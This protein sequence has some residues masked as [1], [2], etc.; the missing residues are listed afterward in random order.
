MGGRAIA[1]SDRIRQEWVFDIRDDFFKMLSSCGLYRY[2]IVG[3]AG[4]KRPEETSG[5]IDIVVSKEELFN[6][7]MGNVKLLGAR[8]RALYPSK[9]ESVV[10]IDG[11]GMI[12]CAYRNEHG[13]FQV[14]VIPVTN[15][16]FAEWGM[17]SAHYLDSKYK[18]GVRNS[19]IYWTLSEKSHTSTEIRDGR[20]VTW[21]R[22]IFDHCEG[23]VELTQTILG[24][25]GKLVKNK[26][27]IAREYV[28]NLNTPESIVEYCF[29]S[30]ASES[31]C[32]C[33]TVE[34]CLTC[35][36][37]SKCL[38]ESQKRN[39]IANVIK[40]C[41]QKNFEYPDELNNWL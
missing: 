32:R 3:S 24:K 38:T 29:D 13:L 40:E 1:N 39:I 4:K 34:Q 16:A 28:K 14:D 25:T 17:H 36:R 31:G 35:L 10:S 19:I 37:H 41:E 23:V 18:S 22:Y 15:I 12:S 20:E 6:S 21:K 7:D 2:T 33:L 30:F 11:F 26:R 8:L 9:I 5:D 27:T